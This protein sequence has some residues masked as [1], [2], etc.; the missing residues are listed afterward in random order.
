M[1]KTIMN[2]KKAFGAA[3]ATM[4]S[5][6]AL[7]GCATAKTSSTAGNKSSDNTIRIGVNL[8][9]SG[10]VA[11]YGQQEKKGVVLAAQEINKKGVKIGGKTYKVKLYISDKIVAQV[12]PV[13]TPYATASIA[14]LTKAGVPMVGPSATASEFTQTKSGQTQKYAFRACFIDP[15]QGKKAADFMYNTLKKKSVAILADNSTD[16]GTGLTKSFT[17]KFKML[18]GKVVTTQYFQSGDKDFNSTLTTIKGK[19]PD[20]LYLPGYYT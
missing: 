17:K 3:A 5:A 8:E 6:A 15:F 9:L 19:K 4:M 12:G 16:Y 13:A 7:T 10:L 20:V 1:G 11:S 18:G 2:F 14:N